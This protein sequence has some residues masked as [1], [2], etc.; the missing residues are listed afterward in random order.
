MIYIK[1]LENENLVIRE[2]INGM[3]YSLAYKGFTKRV[4][5]YFILLKH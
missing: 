4:T 3:I 5:K 2:F 1:L